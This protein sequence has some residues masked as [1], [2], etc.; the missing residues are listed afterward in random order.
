M[1]R[2]LLYI[3]SFAFCVSAQAWDWWPLPMAQ[4]DTCRDSLFYQFSISATAGSGKYNTFWMQSEEQGSVS[5][6]PY[7]G[8]L[9]VAI[10]KPATRPNRWF[11]YDG[12]VD[13]LGMVHSKLPIPEALMP[14]G[15]FPVYQ[16]RQGAY[17]LRQC[18]V[19]T[20]LYIID[21]TAGV[22][23]M[24]DD[25]NTPLGSGSLLLSHNAP[26]LPGIRIGFDRWTP[27]PGL[28][29]YAELKGGMAHAWLTDGIGTKRSKLHY[30]WAGVQFGGSLPVNISY[31]LHHAA[32]WGGYDSE[33]HDLGND[34][35]AFR[36]VFMAQSGGSSYSESFNALGN[37]LG[38][39]QL[40]V[41]ANGKG[42]NVKIYWQNI[43]E[44]NFNFIG[45]GHNLPDGRWGVC[46]QQQVW[47]FIH[48]LTMEYICTT[49]Q[50]GPL[51]DQD[52]I[53]YAG[54]DEY[55]V[56]YTYPQGW[57][58]YLRSLGTPLI[59]SPLYNTTEYTQTLNNRIQAW[60]IGVAGDIYGFQYRLLGTY[61][62]NYGTY[63]YDDWYTLKSDNTA[64]LLDVSKRVEKA[65]GLDF[66]V[67][68]GAD[69]GTQWG[70]KVSAM[71]TISKQ[72]QITTYQ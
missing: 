27:I 30:K 45:M 25:M 21:I 2:V 12:A 50:S 63:H 31:E 7:S 72:G 5:I 1:R 44:D 59:T 65:W 8:A 56:N 3:V 67:R 13:I 28:F 68:I 58:Y 52:G 62:R 61:V 29:G 6:S 54:R 69:F 38:S 64:L 40:A 46:A 14:T 53:I 55:Y 9:R 70:N 48:T 17:I 36:R 51:H 34:W 49:D 32:Q 66:G 24:A 60:H 20:R 22:M 71:I 47:P 23:S 43:L 10:I 18:Y 41:T 19:H 39:Q 37:H 33:G 42:W 57:N 15:R 4:P 16:G 35:N 26:A 11:D